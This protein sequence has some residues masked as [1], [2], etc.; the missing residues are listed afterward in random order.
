[1]HTAPLQL[2]T[3]LTLLPRTQ[4][5]AMPDLCP[6]VNLK[7]C[8]HKNTFQEDDVNSCC[9]SKCCCIRTYTIDPLMSCKLIKLVLFS[10]W[11]GIWEHGYWKYSSCNS[12]ENT[13]IFCDRNAE[14]GATRY[15][16][17]LQLLNF[18]IIMLYISGML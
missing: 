13:D 8:G 14:V 17:K 5:L 6:R 10:V 11:K 4:S 2:Y 15:L 1:M 18:G 16:F 7:A 9:F 12:R 3:M